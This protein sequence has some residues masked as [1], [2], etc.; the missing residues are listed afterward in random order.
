VRTRRDRINAALGVS[1][2]GI[3]A[4]GYGCATEETTTFGEPSRVTTTG[5][6]AVVSVVSSSATGMTCAF[7]PACEVS[8]TKDIYPSLLTSEKAGSGGCSDSN[9]HEKPAGGL[10]VHPTDAKEAYK[11]ILAYALPNYG[12]YLT[13]C[14]PE[15]STILCNLKF[16]KDVENE[17][18][19]DLCG[20]PM[21]KTDSSSPVHSPITKKS[22]DQLVTWIQ[23]GALFN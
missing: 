8:W 20:Q 3:A 5:S 7:N 22:Y 19:S 1:L 15:Q 11:A 17:F 23:C 21:P 4:L 13:P 6:T 16:A 14:A 2:M 10:A 18:Y 9:C 12:P